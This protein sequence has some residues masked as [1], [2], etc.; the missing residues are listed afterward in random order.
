MLPAN[1]HPCQSSQCYQIPLRTG[2]CL[3]TGLSPTFCLL[4]PQTSP[5]TP[6]VDFSYRASQNIGRVIVFRL[7]TRLERV[8]YRLF[9]LGGNTTWASVTISSSK[10]HERRRKKEIKKL[11][12]LSLQSLFRCMNNK[13]NIWEAFVTRY[14]HSEIDSIDYIA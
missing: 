11:S 2:C 8:S 13:T 3:H 1:L 5:V 7:G 6:I 9:L 12:V 4:P 10:L 14:F